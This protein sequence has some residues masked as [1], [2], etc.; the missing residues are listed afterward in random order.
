M[1]VVS[2]GGLFGGHTFPKTGWGRRGRLPVAPFTLIISVFEDFDAPRQ[3]QVP[4]PVPVRTSHPELAED[5]FRELNF[6]QFCNLVR[7]GYLNVRDLVLWIPQS[8]DA[9][10]AGAA[11]VIDHKIK[12]ELPICFHSDQRKS[13]C[14]C[15]SLCLA[16]RDN[17]RVPPGHP[18]SPA[19]RHDS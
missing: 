9:D 12:R 16:D 6:A 3:Y 4:V 13:L 1:E 18:A 10:K 7:T 8:P 2:R 5:L 17:R 14:C 15:I 11:P 19:E